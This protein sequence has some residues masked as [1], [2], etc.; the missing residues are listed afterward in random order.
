MPDMTT[1]D[2]D[3]L[4][5]F[6]YKQEL[7][8]SLGAF[9]AFA[10]GFAFISILT[11]MFLLFG[12]AYGS[13][14]P[15]S[16][17]SWVIAVAGQMLFALAFA[18][19]AV[20]YPL[21]GS[22]YNWAKQIG[23]KAISYFAGVS[24]ILALIVS[25]AGVALAMQNILPAIWTGFQIYG[26]GTGE[27]DFTING[28]ILGSAAIVLA[29]IISLCGARVRSITNNI[30]VSVELIGVAIMIVLLLFHV[31]RGPQVAFDTLG[32]GL[33]YP[34]GYLGALMVCMLVGL[35]VQWGFDTAGSVGEETINP[36]QTSPRAIIRALLVSGIFGALLFLVAF[37]SL[38]D[39]NDPQI[40]QQG[41]AYVLKSVLGDTIGKFLL[42]CA[43]IAVF[44]AVL[45][46]QTGAVNMI[47]AMARDNALPGSPRLAAVNARSRTPIVPPI[48]EGILAI[49]VLVA[50]MKQ[51]QILTVVTAVT[52]TF[53]LISYVLVAGPFALTRMRGEWKTT[54]KGYF[55]LG[56]WGL[57]V[58]IAAFV[59]GVANII[60]L[61]WPR[62]IIYNTTAPY[63]WYLQWG[64]VIIPGVALAACFL[65]YWFY[66]R[67]RIGI[68]S[69]HASGPA[70]ELGA[71][72]SF[73][74]IAEAPEHA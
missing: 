72:R 28:V 15:A 20:H 46:N 16:I 1:S 6:G 4:A 2:D 3:D 32:T 33:T 45:A 9:S 36:R 41:L 56:R 13:G 62:D 73:G 24:M 48:L 27:Y 64:G 60:N 26:D 37:M 51:P 54:E 49:L 40:A 21:A 35:T 70:P 42:I 7:S 63:H 59:W 31:Q 19:L 52:A 74:G 39:L 23:G 69:S 53:A 55:T 61:A 71:T 44:V 8:R 18:E 11:G 10:T 47:F 57:P 43:A 68:L 38:K 66:Q 5:T 14:G 67:N 12:F 34:A 30:G 17:W 29:T 25:T 22:V 58:S 50:L 65:V